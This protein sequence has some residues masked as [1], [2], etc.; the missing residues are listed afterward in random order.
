MTSEETRQLPCGCNIP[1]DSQW[2]EALRKLGKDGSE[3]GEQA[4]TE[5][6]ILE[7]LAKRHK[8]SI[9]L[10][11]IGNDLKGAVFAFGG[12][13]ASPELTYLGAPIQADFEISY[14]N[15]APYVTSVLDQ[16]ALL[17]GAGLPV[18]LVEIKLGAVKVW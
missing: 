15:L 7:D 17:E 6:G 16:A 10:R 13:R 9:P 4:M 3:P 8:C 2:F 14:E 12:G 18:K 5:A 1:W 11:W